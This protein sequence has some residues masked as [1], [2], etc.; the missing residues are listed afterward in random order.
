ML[1]F[2]DRT[3]SL[4][5]R[6]VLAVL[7]TVGSA[8]LVIAWLHV[9]YRYV[10]NDSLTWSEELLKVLLI[11]FGLLCVSFISADRGHVSIVVFKQKMPRPINEF[12][13]VLSGV[14]IYIASLMLVYVGIRM[15]VNSVGRTTPALGIPY[16]WAY[17]AVPVSFFIISIYELRNV[18]EML[19]RYNRGTLEEMNE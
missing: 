18:V 13:T 1:K 12:F 19:V 17:A 9:F 16:V 6:G 7:T 14:L 10:L 2:L 3:V 4:L 11:W 5:Q 15:M 8:M